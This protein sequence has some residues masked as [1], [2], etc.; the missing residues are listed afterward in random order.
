MTFARAIRT[1]S[2]WPIPLWQQAA[3]TRIALQAQSQL[4]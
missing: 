1:G 2:A 3:A 4:G